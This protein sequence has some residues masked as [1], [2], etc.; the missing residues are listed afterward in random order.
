MIPLRVTAKAGPDGARVVQVWADGRM[1]GAATLR[2]GESMADLLR[3]AAARA[4]A[5]EVRS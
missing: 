5:R 1:V 4:K 2:R 3:S